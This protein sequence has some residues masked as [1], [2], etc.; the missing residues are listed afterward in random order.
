MRKLPALLLIIAVV[1]PL[2]LAALALFSVSPWVAKRS[3]YHQLLGDERLYEALL[4]DARFHKDEP[5]P[6]GD[7]TGL[8][9]LQ[10]VPA[11]AL[12]KALADT[13]SGGYL[14]DQALR[15]VDGT[16]D[17]MEGS[18][19]EAPPTLDLEPLKA[20]LKGP[21]RARFTRSLA[22]ALPV[23]TSGQDPV[24][25]SG[26]LRCRPT[27]MSTQR[28]VQLLSAA[29]PAAVDRLPDSWPFYGEGDWPLAAPAARFWAGS[30]GTARWVWAAVVVALVAAGFWVGAAFIGGRNRREVFA[31]LG[32]PLLFTA[33]LTLL[34]GLALRLTFVGRRLLYSCPALSV[35]L[36]GVLRP[37]LDTVSNGFLITGAVA[38]GLAL[39]LLAASRVSERAR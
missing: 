27:G 4:S 22:E 20:R 31:F 3:F 5:W 6:V 16:F 29:L 25:P 39:G 37:A 30:F 11:E 14:R 26:M 9:G 8:P 32:W 15:L 10:E 13:V 33:L 34:C 2:L 1:I 38:A 24:A 21:D 7:W 12:A 36:S 23:C 35:S 17:A 19:S 28:A 18:G